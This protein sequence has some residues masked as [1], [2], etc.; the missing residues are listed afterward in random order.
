MH[1]ARKY[2]AVLF[3]L[4]L[5]PSMTTLAIADEE[6]TF[7][8]QDASGKWIVGLKAGV[9]QNG[10]DGF[11][12]ATN[13]GVVLGYR[14]DRAIGEIGASSSIELEFTTSV[15]DGDLSNVVGTW[16]VDTYALFFTY[17]TPG[18]VYFK[19]KL[20]VM[21]TD[22]SSSVVGVVV[23]DD[24]GFGYGAGFGVRAGQHARFELEYTG[25]AGVTGENDINFI[26]LGGLLE[27]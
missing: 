26:S 8:G 7:F 4:A 24:S 11:G 10:T 23:N 22:V 9:M 19:G 18:T 2:L 25:V 1:I 27:F 5:T 15:D 13:A 21:A 3:T 17:A 6:G 16:E 14:F 20:G 12:D